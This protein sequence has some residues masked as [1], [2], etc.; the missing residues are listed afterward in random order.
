MFSISTGHSPLPGFASLNL[1]RS[2]MNWF[3]D[4]FIFIC[5]YQLISIELEDRGVMDN[6]FVFLPIF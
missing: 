6:L 4:V 5:I 3:K 1:T 2:S